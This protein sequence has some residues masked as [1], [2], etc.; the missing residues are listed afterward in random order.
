MKNILRFTTAGSVDAGKSTLIGRLF[1]DSKKIFK[2]QLSAIELKSKSKGFD[3]IDLSLYTDGLKAEREQGITIDVA[4]RYFATPKRKFIIA[5]TPGHIEYTRNMVTGA[6]T[7]NAAVILIEARKGILEQTRRHTILSS[8]LGIKHLVVCVNKMD[9][10]DY[11]EE[12]FNAIVEQFQE[13]LKSVNVSTCDFIPISALGGDN[14]INK[15]E[16]M[17]WYKGYTLIETL[18]NVDLAQDHQNS[19]TRLAVQYVI[20]PQKFEFQ[21][22]RGYAGRIAGNGFRIGDEIAVALS[23]KKS[24][25]TGIYLGE[26]T[27]NI[28]VHGESVT[29][30][31]SDDIDISRG[32]MLTLSSEPCSKSSSFTA[33]ICWFFEKPMALQQKL[34]LRIGTLKT[35]VMVSGIHSKLNIETLSNEET[36]TLQLNEIGEVEFISSEEIPYDSYLKQ[37]ASGSFILV[38][39]QHLNTIGGGMIL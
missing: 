3:Y 1:Y 13:L 39:P 7:A 23:E 20:R 36:T 34:I 12:Q 5:D 22:F 32:D 11:S 25:I 29:I 8:L 28:A 26:D 38:D 31:L 9:L 21:D 14:V 35:M 16:A 37:Q 30:T 17:S 33:K 2:D 19:P 10:I 6:S 18:E 4:Y 27:R 15:S 24:T